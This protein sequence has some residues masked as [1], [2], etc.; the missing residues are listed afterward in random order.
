MIAERSS[1][2]FSLVSFGVHHWRSLKNPL[3]CPYK[4]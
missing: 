1:R 3:L 2:Q 4:H